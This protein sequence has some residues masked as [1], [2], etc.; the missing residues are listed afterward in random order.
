[1]G[2]TLVTDSK[3]Q[4]LSQTQWVAKL[5]SLFKF[6]GLA[7][8]YFFMLSPLIFVIWLSFFA[9]SIPA[10]PPTGYS[11]KWYVNAWENQAFMDGLVL[12]LKLGVIAAFGSVVF[13]TAAAIALNTPTMVGRSLI[14]S[15]L[16]SP[17][18]VPS[19]VAGVAVYLFFLRAE[20]VLDRNV[21]G[22]FPALVIAHI[23]IT[24]PW[25]LRLVTANLE[26][27]DVT[28]EEAARNLGASAMVVFWRVTLPMLRPAIVASTLFSFI[29]SFENLEVTLP[30]V[31]PGQTTLPIAIMQY[32][33]FSLDPT[34]AAVS[35]VQIALLAIVM[36]V[37][38]RFVKIS[39]VI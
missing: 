24:I 26:S 16:L 21:V 22:T 35:A 34:I 10:F 38:N 7:S 39:Q 20:D 29:I 27:I 17:L 13:G 9:D 19:I 18:V 23:C 1:M 14:R 36:V 15:I 6:V 33:E 3:S 8:I 25:T 5:L 2:A 4:L 32:L 37:S 11:L 12:S 31:G 28:I 30:L